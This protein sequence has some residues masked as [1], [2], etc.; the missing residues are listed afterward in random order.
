MAKKKVNTPVKP[1]KPLPPPLPPKAPYSLGE[2]FTDP[3]LG[4]RITE[5]LNSEEKRSGWVWVQRDRRVIVSPHLGSYV[6]YDE[7]GA[8]WT[9]ESGALWLTKKR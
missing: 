5:I 8:K 9:I 2:V 6:W 7:F 3:Y 4:T 1:I